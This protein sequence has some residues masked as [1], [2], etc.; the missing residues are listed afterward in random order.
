M[1]VAY[2]HHETLTFSG[3]LNQDTGQTLRAEPGGVYDIAPASG[4]A[5][6]EVPSPW[7]VPAGED[8]RPAPLLES[9]PGPDEGAEEGQDF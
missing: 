1:R 6:D 7:F 3:Y 5:A 4:R 9:E 8:D 2:V